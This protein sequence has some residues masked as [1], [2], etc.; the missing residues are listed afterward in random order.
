ML[1]KGMMILN[2]LTQA[3]MPESICPENETAAF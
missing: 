1:L 2:V 3:F